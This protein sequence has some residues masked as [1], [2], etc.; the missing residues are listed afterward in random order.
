VAVSS[1]ELPPEERLE[2][3]DLV[4]EMSARTKDVGPNR[5][6]WPGL[7]TYRFVRPQPPQWS[8]VHSLSLCCVVQGRKRVVVDDA[9]HRYGPFR[10]L[11]C[12]RGMRFETEILEASVERPFLSFVL[13]IDPAIVRSVSSEI[14]DRRTTTF[15]RPTRSR[16][17]E[18]ARPHVSP[19]DQNLMG[20]VLRFL[21]SLGAEADRRVLAPMY[22]REIAY[23]LMQAEQVSRLVEAAAVE[24]E[25]NPVS[26]VIRFVR[27]RMSEP[28]TVA[29]M[30]HQ[31]R[32]SP[33]ALT[34]VFTEATGMGPYQFVKRMRLH[35]AVTLL[36]Q[37]DVNVSDV[38]RHVGYVSV[39]HFINEFKR[40]YGTTPRAYVE[41]QRGTVAMR[42]E[43]ATT[44]TDPG[45]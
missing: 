35:R 41:A 19:V 23:R 3:V 15:S 39:S 45:A 18:P 14:A 37:E 13:Q 36:T 26:E 34:S 28:L 42:V 1:F 17:R 33:S 30:A 31:V 8:E 25:S 24:R 5:S 2:P 29:D 22:L 44:R 10:Y 27:E 7:T 21:R 43:E 38:S 16:S 4:T 12:T 32:M 40:Y 9:E 11:L 20:A 6:E